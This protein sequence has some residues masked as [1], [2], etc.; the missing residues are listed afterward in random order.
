MGAIHHCLTH[1]DISGPVNVVVPN[2]STNFDFTKTLGSVLHRPTIFPMPAFAA[3]LSLGEMAE[4]LL[5]S[6]TRVGPQRLQETGY[7]FRCPTLEAALKHL[8]GTK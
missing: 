4:E 1:E 3:K 6:S 7:Q 8:L 5:L 2:A